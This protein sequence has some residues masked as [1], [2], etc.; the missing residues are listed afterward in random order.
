MKFETFLFKTKMKESN[1]DSVKNV[2][3]AVTS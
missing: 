1:V 2:S 3:K